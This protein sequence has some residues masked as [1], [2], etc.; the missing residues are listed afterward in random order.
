MDSGQRN[1]TISPTTMLE[2][3]EVRSCNN[4]MDHLD[5]Q[6]F[7]SKSGVSGTSMRDIAE[8]QAILLQCAQESR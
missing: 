1:T 6:F 4:N 7:L 3:M 2:A 5:F 8:D